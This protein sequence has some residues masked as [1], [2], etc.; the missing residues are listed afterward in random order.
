MT[1]VHG[2]YALCI[3]FINTSKFQSLIDTKVVCNSLDWLGVAEKAN[4]TAALII[5][6]ETQP[7]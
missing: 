7:S 2:M 4:V 5:S 3:Y 1:C 6:N